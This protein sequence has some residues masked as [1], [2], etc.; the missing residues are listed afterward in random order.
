[1]N[2]S[3][4]H[5]RWLDRGTPRKRLL[6]GRGH[7]GE[8]GPQGFAALARLPRS[9]GT[10][11]GDGK[12]PSTKPPRLAG[13]FA[14]GAEPSR[15][16][17]GR[18]RRTL[19]RGPVRRRALDRR[20]RRRLRVSGGVAIA[21]QETGAL[22]APLPL[23][24]PPP[25]VTGKA[26]TRPRGTVQRPSKSL[27][28]AEP[29]RDEAPR[30]PPDLF[31]PP[32]VPPRARHRSS[33]GTQG[34]E[35]ALCEFLPQRPRRGRPTAGLAVPW[36]RLEGGPPAAAGEGSTRTAPPQTGQ[37]DGPRASSSGSASHAPHPTPATR[38]TSRRK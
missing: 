22:P 23:R 27:P 38:V 13:R 33:R 3:A 6:N 9:R 15:S 28:T 19:P 7:R 24:Q 25:P 16:G 37:P 20:G 14:R 26:T 18:C 1:M 17:R 30:L 29:G 12:S 31:P 5:E 32:R 35:R 21:A 4:E 2:D 36:S 10:V 11:G 34:P 8:P